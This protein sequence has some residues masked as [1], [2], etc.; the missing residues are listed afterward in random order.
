MY[1]STGLFGMILTPCFGS[2]TWRSFFWVTAG[3][4][5]IA[6]LAI[7]FTV[8]PDHIDEKLDRRVDWI[9]AAIITVALVLLT[10]VL[11][12]GEVASNGWA[13]ACK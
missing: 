6:A 5:V 2:S 10:F 3:M 1:S 8:P 4:M 13:T 9:G 11:A 12:Q 7:F